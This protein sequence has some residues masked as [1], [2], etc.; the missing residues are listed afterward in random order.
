MKVGS[1]VSLGRAEM[2]GREARQRWKEGKVRNEEQFGHKL[3]S[4]SK[5]GADGKLS[6]PEVE[7]APIPQKQLI[8]TKTLRVEPKEET[9]FAIS[10]QVFLPYIVAGLGLTLAGITL[11]SF[12]QNWKVFKQIEEII[13]LIPAL[14]GLKGNLEMTLASRLSTAA[15]TGQ[16]DSR[17]EQWNVVI[18]NLAVIQVQ[19]TVAGLLAALAAL[20]LGATIS[21]QMMLDKAIVLCASSITTAFVTALVLGLV[22][23]AVIILSRKL[24]INPDNIAAPIAAS[25]GDLITLVIL[26][27]VS[28]IFYEYKDCYF[29]SPLVCCAFIS[30]IPLWIVIAK[31]NPAI[32]EIL[33][34]GWHPIIIAMGISSLGGLILMETI[35][36]PHFEGMTVFSPVINGGNLVAV[37]ASRISTFLHF[38]STPG[39]LPLGMKSHCPHPCSTF[40]GSG[41]NSKSARVLILLVIPGHLL[42]LYITHTLKKDNTA[43]IT[44]TFVVLYLFMALLQVWILLYLADVLVRL[45]WWKSMDPDNYSIPFLT[46]LGDLFGTGLL[47]LCFQLV[48]LIGGKPTQSANSTYVSTTTAHP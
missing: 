7:D 19:A 4:Q 23:V 32:L 35:S 8:A 46:G 41:S 10:L 27:A 31:R 13:T 20:F 42:F 14:V 12:Q 34:F 47:A 26:A 16:M 1:N 15:N 2:K 25:L 39:V 22:M 28:S 3:K 5:H 21:K 44:S 43:F 33:K 9:A 29:L 45:L 40:F 17:S 30:L 18:S 11:E 37:Q 24:E 48:W 6:G 38:W 36:K